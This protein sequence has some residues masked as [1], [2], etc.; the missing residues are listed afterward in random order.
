MYCYH[1]LRNN[2]II[3]R[4]VSWTTRQRQRVLQDLR[5]HSNPFA[6]L[7]AG[8]SLFALCRC[9]SPLFEGWTFGLPQ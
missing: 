1:Y 9:V 7:M 5:V 6:S 4:V 8:S 2:R 3:P